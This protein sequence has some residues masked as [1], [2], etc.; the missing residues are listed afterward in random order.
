MGS[1]TLVTRFARAQHDA[2]GDVTGEGPAKG[3]SLKTK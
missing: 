3:R 2:K 1:I